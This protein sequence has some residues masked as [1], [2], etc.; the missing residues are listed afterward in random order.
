MI[1]YE[2]KENSAPHM[3][4]PLFNYNIEACDFCDTN[5]HQP[6]MPVPDCC[7]PPRRPPVCPVRPPRHGDPN[8][9]RR[10]HD[11]CDYDHEHH[12]RDDHGHGHH[13]HDEDHDCFPPKRSVCCKWE[14]ECDYD[15]DRDDERRD[16]PRGFGEAFA[17]SNRAT[18]LRYGRNHGR[19]D[20][21]ERG[22][23]YDDRRRK[24]DGVETEI[25]F[26]RRDVKIKG[27]AIVPYTFRK[28]E[29][30]K[31]F[32]VRESAMYLVEYSFKVIRGRQPADGG[33]SVRGADIEAN[34]APMPSPVSAVVYPLINRR[35]SQRLSGVKASVYGKTYRNADKYVYL[36]RGDYISFAAEALIPA[37]PPMGVVDFK[38]HIKML[39]GKRRERYEEF[40]DD[41]N[42][43][44]NGFQR[45]DSLSNEEKQWYPASGNARAASFDGYDEWISEFDDAPS[46]FDYDDYGADDDFTDEE[47]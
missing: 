18:I 42:V 16:R 17:I 21:H 43:R 9:G 28:D 1:C 4:N 47:F 22:R 27:N 33:V 32:L 19:R 45:F 35:R 25:E 13:H 24:S 31:M 10:H 44:L 41:D 8:C 7:E 29:P 30:I 39:D 2:G 3:P 34:I 40:D 46:D 37:K 5:Y 6:A 26:L 15:C 14:L 20:H 12:R 11:D 38:V 36:R 23:D